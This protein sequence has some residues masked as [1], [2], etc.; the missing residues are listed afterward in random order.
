[1]QNN[2]VIL[3]SF[4]LIPNK[5]VSYNSIFIKD[6]STNELKRFSEIRKTKAIRFENVL[7]SKQVTKSFHN[8]EISK[9]AY[10][11]LKSKISWLYYLANSNKITLENKKMIYNF[12]MA[13]ITLTLPSKQKHNT[14]TIT[15]E[16]LNQFITELRDKYNMRNYVW[17]LE[18]Q[19]NGNVHYHIA[20]DAFIPYKEI[21]KVWNRQMYKL[22]YVQEYQKKF[23]GMS[24]TEYNNLYNQKGKIEFNKIKE[25]FLKAKKANWANPPTVDVKSVVSNKS[26]ANY[27]SKYFSKGDNGG[28][29]KNELDNEENSFGLRLWF[30]SRSLSK[31]SKVS[32]F[33]EAVK[34]DIFAI[35]SYAKSKLTLYNRYSSSTYFEIMSMPKKAKKWIEKI[36]KGYANDKEYIPWNLSRGEYG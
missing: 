22:G 4:S 28:V 16:C 13:F 32:N 15:N 29:I 36:L 8:W 23:S 7:K 3:P 2:L 21:R 26:I 31:L 27:I 6:K 24:L 12:K 35:V 18:F 17:R 19:K 10:R 5:L 33:C 34:Y 20:T 9:N 30:C 1:M 14:Q 25:R 11:N